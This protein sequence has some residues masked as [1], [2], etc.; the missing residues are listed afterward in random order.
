MV[1]LVELRESKFSEKFACARAGGVLQMEQQAATIP[2]DTKVC[3]PDI[4]LKPV[5]RVM[6]AS[7]LPLR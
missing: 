3:S 6:V 1:E 5:S 2:A 4:Q 7:S